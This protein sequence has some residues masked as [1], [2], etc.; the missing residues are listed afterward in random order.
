MSFLP[1]M[2]LFG[3]GLSL[4]MIMLLSCVSLARLCL[5]VAL[6]YCIVMFTW[7]AHY[8]FSSG[9]HEWHQMSQ[10]EICHLEME[11]SERVFVI[12]LGACW[13]P[14]CVRKVLRSWLNLSSS[15]RMK[16][17]PP[18]PPPDP[19]QSRCRWE[20]GWD[21]TPV[22]EHPAVPGFSGAWK[23]QCVFGLTNWFILC[24]KYDK[25]GAP[26]RGWN[27]NWCLYLDDVAA[28]SCFY[29]ISVLH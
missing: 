29:V 13:L 27:N 28:S 15:S 26:E 12:Y 17:D 7:L 10:L 16:P 24:V 20:A 9:E 19:K 8:G 5:S 3:T 22:I 4:L 21:L 2:C 18:P 14:L 1:I 23:T 25:K 11:Q 6:F